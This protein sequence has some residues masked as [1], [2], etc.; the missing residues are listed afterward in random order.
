MRCLLAAALVAC[1]M[2]GGSGLSA[3]AQSPSPSPSSI[4]SND[5]EVAFPSVE[6][7]GHALGSE[8]E[9]IGVRADMG[10][11]WEGVELE[12][13]AVTDALMQAYQGR[14][15]GHE[16]AAAVI[17]VE[18][19]RFRSRDEAASYG[20]MVAAAISGPLETFDADLAAELVATGSFASDEGFGGST[21]LVQEGPVVAIVTA[22]RTG[23]QEMET[24][25]SAVT[26]LV[27]ERLG[28]KPSE[29]R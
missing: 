10:Q 15:E 25:S 29:P 23:A 9:T 26:A 24:A 3:A 4:T 6:E 17:V 12:P 28:D 20:G 2:T 14:S 8:V 21:I 18:I 11:L 16:D 22:Y 27:L 19:V 13:G 5:P 1:L 7:V